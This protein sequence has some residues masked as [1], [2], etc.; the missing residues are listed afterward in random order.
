MLQVQGPLFWR[1]SELWCCEP[2]VSPLLTVLDVYLNTMPKGIDR[3]VVVLIFCVIREHANAHGFNPLE[4]MCGGCSAAA[5]GHAKCKKGHGKEYIEFKCRYC[6]SM[7]TYFCFGKTHFC[8]TC[9]NQRPDLRKDSALP[10]CKGARY[11]PL[12]VDHA[13][14]GQE[15]CLG[16]SMCRLEGQ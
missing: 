12:R 11:C 2:T 8:D 10:K 16:C 3:L 9:H 1:S 4:L 5:S 13:P 14:N 7:A 6:C 15:C